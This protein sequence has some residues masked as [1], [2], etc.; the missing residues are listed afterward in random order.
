M[1]NNEKLSQIKT[2][3]EE[4]KKIIGNLGYD[5]DLESK[6]EEMTKEISRLKK[7]IEESIDE[8]DQI[9]GQEDARS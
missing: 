2:T 1:T 3:I 6:I 8:L 4:I 9:I 5:N 7:G